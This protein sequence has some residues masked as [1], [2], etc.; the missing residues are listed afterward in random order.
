[1]YRST[2][3]KK[4]RNVTNEC[5][6]IQRRGLIVT[7]MSQT[8][9]EET[10]YRWGEV[11]DFRKVKTPWDL[12]RY[13][14]PIKV[15]EK[16]FTLRQKRKFIIIIL[17]KNFKETVCNNDFG[18]FTSCSKVFGNDYTVLRLRKC[19]QYFEQDHVTGVFCPYFV[20]NTWRIETFQI[21]RGL[22]RCKTFCSPRR[23]FK[24]KGVT[25]R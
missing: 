16:R 10:P 2:L 3:V 15:P 5:Q 25:L 8:Q 18:L 12:R 21:D 9:R 4:R 23:T 22:V 14:S 11:L 7:L 6:S 17:I 1:M 19:V 13:F 20:R 24:S